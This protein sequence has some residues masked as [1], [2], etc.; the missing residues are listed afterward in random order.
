MD[1]NALLVN[2]VEKKSSDLFLKVGSPPSMRVDGQIQFIGDQPL[3]PEFMQQTLEAISNEHQKEIFEKESELDTA[4]ESGGNRFRVSVFRQR[5]HIGFVFR[6]VPSTIFT[7]D[8]LHL[9]GKEL[10]KLSLLKRGMVLITGTKGSGKS[11]ALAAM[12]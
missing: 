9:P 5:S 8:E 10:T 4:H 12:V 1:F 11:T 7:F 2:M 3:T 6:H